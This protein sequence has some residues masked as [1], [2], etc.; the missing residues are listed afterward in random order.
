MSKRILF[1]LGAGAAYNWFDG[2]TGITTNSITT[3]ICCHHKLCCVLYHKIKEQNN[4]VNFE[5]IINAIEN[6]YHYYFGSK[7]YIDF[8]NSILFEPT[9]EIQNYFKD[10]L[11][12]EI[13]M[14][15][16][17]LFE[18]CIS[19]IIKEIGHYDCLIKSPNS[20]NNNRFLKFLK[21]TK[22]ENNIIRAYTL[23]Y[24]QMFLD[25]DYRNEMKFYD[26]F[27]NEYV[28]EKPIGFNQKY[29][30]FD[31][32]EILN[33]TN[34]NCFYNL[35]GS[36]YWSKRNGSEKKGFNPR[37]VKSSEVFNDLEWKNMNLGSNHQT[38]PNERILHSPIITGFK[39]LQRLNLEPFNAFWN[40]FYLDCH[41]AD[42]YVFIGY[43]FNDPHIN[44]V[45]ASAQ[46]TNKKVL[47]V[48]RDLKNT[49][50]QS[51]IGDDFNVVIDNRANS[52]G[53]IRLCNEGI[54]DFLEKKKYKSFKG[55]F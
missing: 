18:D 50:L 55:F 52:K 25:I 46:L 48:D 6:L 10:R 3:K 51:I 20:P 17:D 12:N 34:D 7:D 38:N 43:S 22:A 19:I 24:D 29:Y 49:N 4:N 39:K 16:A 42:V 41:Q 21:F 14:E 53:N 45:L 5:N 27:Q 32:N 28:I 47:I 36:I 26:G 23:N 15:L 1:L 11:N 54:S 13:V 33:H 44:N 2:I 37:I 31:V 40:S 30:Q 8:D 35:H 9:K